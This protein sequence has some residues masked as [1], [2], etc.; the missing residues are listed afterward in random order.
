[1][2]AEKGY[3]GTFIAYSQ[4]GTRKSYTVFGE[5]EHSAAGLCDLVAADLFG[6]PNTG[7]YS[8]T[9]GVFGKGRKRHMKMLVSFLELYNERLRDL[10]VGSVSALFV[11][12]LRGRS[13][14][15]RHDRTRLAGCDDLDVVEPPEQGVMVPHLTTVRVYSVDELERLLIEGSRRRAKASTSSNEVSSRSHAIVQFT[16]RRCVGDGITD[17]EGMEV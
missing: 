8:A 1:M 17:G 4:T 5:M 11:D 15:A 10:I 13:E 16:V 14:G 2:A 6:Q 9:N 12:D 3:N 7:E